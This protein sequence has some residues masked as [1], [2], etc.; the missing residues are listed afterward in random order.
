VE[1]GWGEVLP[2]P[3]SQSKK[4]SLLARPQLLDQCPHHRHALY[5]CKDTPTAHHTA[6]IVA[7]PLL[8][9][10]PQQDKQNGNPPRA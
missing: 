4:G 6:A 8:S 9:Y 10:R 2:R 3:C 1:E 7:A 5:L